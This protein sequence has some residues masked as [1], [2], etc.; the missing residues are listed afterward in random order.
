VISLAVRG[1]DNDQQM[2]MSK[3]LGRFMREDPTFHVRTD[4]E[5]GETVISGMGELH[6]DIYIERMRREYAVDV[7][8]G[9]P[10]VNYREAITSTAEFDHLHKKQTGG[11][12]QYA[13]VTGMIEPLAEDHENGFEFVNQIFGGA[14]PSEHIPACEKGFKDV[15]SK[16][17]LAAFPMVGIKVTLNDGKYHDVDSSDLAYQLAARTAM[18]DAVKKSSPVLMEPVM[19]V[20]VETP[21]DF[22]GSVIGDLSSRRGVVYGTEVNGDDTVIN[23]GVPLGE[24]FGYATQLRSLT[25][26]KANYSMEF[27]KYNRCPAFVQEKVIKERA[28]KMREEQ[29]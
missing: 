28:E 12:G 4:E 13:G 7:I 21:S 29:G 16:G 14:I 5:S 11:S 25:S 8:V 23:A 10:Q 20:E 1:E 15:M 24:M 6:L 18:R 9:A 2:K 19:K 3:A 22:Q 27:E 26:G 17:P